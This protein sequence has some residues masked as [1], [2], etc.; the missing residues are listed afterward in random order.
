MTRNN[1]F[2]KQALNFDY[3][4]RHRVTCMFSTSP[5]TF[6][7]DIKFKTNKCYQNNIV[8]VSLFGGVR[9]R[10]CEEND[11]YKKIKESGLLKNKT[12]RGITWSMIYVSS[13]LA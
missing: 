9:E 8:S 2:V 7:K 10:T 13:F 4:R 3:I 5:C 6:N 11:L 1:I 12:P